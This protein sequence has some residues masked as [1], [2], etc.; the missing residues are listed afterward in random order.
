MVTGDGDGAG[1]GDG[2]VMFDAPNGKWLT[3]GQA[4]DML[5]A[6]YQENRATFGYYLAKGIAGETPRAPGRRERA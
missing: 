5:T 1:N 4:T 3:L 6:M 2:R